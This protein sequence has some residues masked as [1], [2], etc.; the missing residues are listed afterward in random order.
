MIKPQFVI[1]W[2]SKKKGKESSDG[3]L[4]P[5]EA[6][7]APGDP[8]PNFHSD[9]IF[10]PPKGVY[11]GSETLYFDEAFFEEDRIYTLSL[12]YGFF[13]EHQVKG[14]TVCKGNISSNKVSFKN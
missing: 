7:T 9:F 1:E 11:H 4:G 14:L 5:S 6:L 3:G 10:L 8:G 12:T 13:R 2:H